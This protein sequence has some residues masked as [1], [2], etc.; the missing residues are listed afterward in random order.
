MSEKLYLK[1][2]FK[3]SVRRGTGEAYLLAKKYPDIDFS[4]D[5]IKACIKNFAY[6]GQCESSR[7]PYLFDIILIS[8]KKEK[9]RSAILNAL[10]TEQN[11]TWTLTQLFDLAKMFALEGDTEARQAIYDR[12]YKNPINGSEW[13]GY[14]EIIDLDGLD[15]LL[16]IADRIG[17]EIKTNPDEWP[18]LS[19]IYYF[20]KEYPEI[21]VMQALTQAGLTNPHI[22][23][24]LEH[25][26]LA[27]EESPP[28][29]Q[30][31][32]YQNIVD[33]V[34]LSNRRFLKNNLSSSE[35]DLLARR[36]LTEKNK[37]NRQKLLAVFDRIKFPLD[38]EFIL[39]IAN[40]TVRAD[41]RTVDLAVSALRF[42]RS[43]KIRRFALERAI[44]VNHPDDFLR[45]L[46]SNYK[47]GDEKLLVDFA[48]RAKNEYAVENLAI[49]YIDIYKSNKTPEC[50]RP[51]EIIYDKLTCAIHREDIIKLLIE[52]GVLCDKIKQEIP[53]DCD[54]NTRLLAF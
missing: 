45:I 23:R 53:F 8:D 46:K 15:G 50:R 20:K 44:A 32:V 24:Y 47:K 27:E 22:G 2:L 3:S 42:L 26:K 48:I 37:E 7:A 4:G 36:L 16:F 10:A 29:T 33:E 54:E 51:L 18:D 17:S 49:S 31:P 11:D 30:R 1:Q 38:S 14:S 21:E 19:A 43:D 41:K 5:I 40:R 6:D 28:I 34:L 12:F 39:N 25:I 35:T 9:I 13:A 52:N